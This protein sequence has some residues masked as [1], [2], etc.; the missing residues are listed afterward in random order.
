MRL[1]CDK[2]EASTIADKL[3]E[4]QQCLEPGDAA[5]D[6]HDVDVPAS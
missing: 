4:R 6:D 5:P 3:A 2:R 1:G